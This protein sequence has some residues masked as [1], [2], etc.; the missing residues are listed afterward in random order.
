MLQTPHRH[1]HRDGV[2]ELTLATSTVRR[3]TS[4]A[5]SSNAV[6]SV[7]DSVLRVPAINGDLTSESARIAPP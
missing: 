3:Q 2:P 7:V 5:F 4:I 1:R 6:S